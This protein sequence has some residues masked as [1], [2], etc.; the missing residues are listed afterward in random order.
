MKRNV[1]KLTGLACISMAY[2]IASQQTP[3][4]SLQGDEGRPID[5]AI[6]L[7]D[8]MGIA[9][10]TRSFITT[11]EEG[12]STQKPETDYAQYET[13]LARYE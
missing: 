7:K 2:I 12:Q 4:L 3:N 10:A 6:N 9:I 1:I 8:F 11:R 5:T 13:L